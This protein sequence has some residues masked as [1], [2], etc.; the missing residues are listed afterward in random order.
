MISVEAAAIVG[1]KSDSRSRYLVSKSFMKYLSFLYTLPD[2]ARPS[3]KV[4][5]NNK[6]FGYIMY[7]FSCP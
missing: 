7:A 2:E 3:Q 6:P 1:Y 4:M 5:R